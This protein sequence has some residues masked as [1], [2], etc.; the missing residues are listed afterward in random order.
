MKFIYK[1]NFF[2]V[3]R[4]GNVTFTENQYHLNMNG[5]TTS[6]VDMISIADVMMNWRKNPKL[7]NKDSNDSFKLE[8]FYSGLFNILLSTW[9]ESVALIGGGNNDK[10]HQNSSGLISSSILPTLEIVVK[11]M[12]VSQID[13]CVD[14]EKLYGQVIKNFPYEALHQNM[15]QNLYAYYCSR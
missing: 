14:F 4:F 11:L 15:S 13:D 1:L 9:C 10:R 2:L 7:L 3:N 12:V 6:E 8:Y 5:P